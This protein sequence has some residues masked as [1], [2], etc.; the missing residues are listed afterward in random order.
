MNKHHRLAIRRGIRAALSQLSSGD[1]ARLYCKIDEVANCAA[2]S[3]TD[4]IARL[5]APGTRPALPSS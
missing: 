1:I 5:S 2:V 4:A 3:I